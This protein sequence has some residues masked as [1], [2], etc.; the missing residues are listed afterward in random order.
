MATEQKTTETP[1]GIFKR[2]ADFVSRYANNVRLETYAT[3]MKLIFG[4][5]DMSSGSEAIEQHTAITLAWVQVKLAIYFL[6]INVAAYEIENGPIR[7]PAVLTPP[8]FP[9]EGTAEWPKDP[10]QQEVF[11]KLRQMRDEFLASSK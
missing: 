2:T 7:M 11:T 1:Q 6:Q 9:D 8:P 4:Q 5:S 10:L 3:D